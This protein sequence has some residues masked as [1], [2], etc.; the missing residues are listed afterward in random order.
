[1]IKTRLTVFFFLF[2]LALKAQE[3]TAT[4]QSADIAAPGTTL[5]VEIN[6]TKTDSVSFVKYFHEMPSGFVPVESDSKTGNFTFAD[7]GAKVVWVTLPAENIFTFSYKINIPKD[8]KGTIV[9]NGKISFIVGN[10]RKIFELIRKAVIIEDKK[11]KNSDKKEHAKNEKTTPST[12]LPSGSK[13]PVTAIPAITGKTFRVQIGAFNQ[14]P[15]FDV[16]IPEI[17]TVVLE[18]GITKYFSGNFANYEDAVKR[19]KELI[20]KG[21]LIP[22]IV[23]F[24]DGKI[25]K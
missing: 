17:S 25:R 16:E 8:A 18:N 21:F 5:I 9:L 4:Q 23:S 11:S 24:E 19:K 6:I 14:K 7:N 13:V 20:E 10:E 15:K 2:S 1:M 22:F 3:L 12:K